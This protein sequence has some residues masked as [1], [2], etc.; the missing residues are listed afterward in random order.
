MAD[1]Y[2][3]DYLQLD[4][5]LSSQRLES[6]AA[7]AAQHDEML[8]IIVHQA[9][10][11]WFKEILWELDDVIAAFGED[12]LDE[13]EMGRVNGRLRR[14]TEIQKLLLAQ[15]DV[16][17]TMTS[18][19]FLDFR[20]HL[21]PASGFQSMQFRLIENR[22]GVR[23]EDRVTFGGARYTE[24]L[25]GEQRQAV[26]ASEDDPSIHDLVASWLKR[27][28]FLEEFDFWTVY[29]DAVRSMLEADRDIVRS[30]P[31]LTEEEREAQ[32]RSFDQT[33]RQYEAVFDADKHAALVESGARR[34][35]HRS[36]QA[37]LFISLYRDQTALHQPFRLLE[38]L[39]DIDQGF[40]TWRYRHALM[41]QR[42]VGRRVGTGG[43]AGAA[44]L[45]RNAEKSRAFPDLFSLPTFLIP[46]AKLPPLP[47]ELAEAM[48]FRFE[49]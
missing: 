6:E 19:D 36:F 44:Y 30:N 31:E 11:L 27:T 18:L 28:P 15:I 39:M 49:T 46:R 23:T 12:E 33:F 1:V 24:R 34:L 35:S 25:H 14:V 45:T 17:E 10:E 4:R 38:L 41:T 22:L 13:S 2:Y 26:I 48:R 16:L 43:S 40:T 29:R 32:L 9:Y 42:M 7:G 47:T 37:A 20:D 5:L 21:V 3:H 8:F